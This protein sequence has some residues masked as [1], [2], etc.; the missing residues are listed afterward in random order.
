MNNKHVD[1]LCESA[2]CYWYR[3]NTMS[4]VVWYHD[5]DDA[6]EC[7]HR[8]LFYLTSMDFVPVTHKIAINYGNNTVAEIVSLD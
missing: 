6:R 5:L 7:A 3:D 8:R 1:K 4:G 2:T